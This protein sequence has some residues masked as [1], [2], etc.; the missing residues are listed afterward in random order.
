MK[1]HLKALY[2]YKSY[3]SV[4]YPQEGKAKICVKGLGECRAK[5]Q[6]K[7][8]AMGKA[9]SGLMDKCMSNITKNQL[10]HT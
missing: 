4:G 2:I 6:A 3:N 8:R 10:S 5:N 1:A 9:N 7:W